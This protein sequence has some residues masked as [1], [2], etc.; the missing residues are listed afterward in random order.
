M[1]GVQASPGT[2]TVQGQKSSLRALN[3]KPETQPQT[4]NP[5]TLNP[6]PC[7]DAFGRRVGRPPPPYEAEA[8][9]SEVEFFVSRVAR[10]FGVSRFSTVSRVSRV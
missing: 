5:K 8:R 2:R 4:P 9:T 10:V 6:K 3:P 1:Y 7:E